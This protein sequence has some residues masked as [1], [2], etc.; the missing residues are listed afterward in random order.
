M[1]QFLSMREEKPP[2]GSREGFLGVPL[3]R[4]IPVALLEEAGLLHN[5][6][7]RPHTGFRWTEPLGKAGRLLF[8]PKAWEGCPPGVGRLG[9]APRTGFPELGTAWYCQPQVYMLPST[10]NSFGNSELCRH[11]Q[12]AFWSKCAALF[13]KSPILE[14]PEVSLVLVSPTNPS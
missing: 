7:A 2:A 8:R 6:R 4:A 5:A 13:D 10:E 9:R 14:P 11:S 1:T 3:P 12:Q